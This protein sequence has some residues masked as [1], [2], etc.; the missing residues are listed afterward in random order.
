VTVFTLPCALLAWLLV[1]AA[2]AQ[3]ATYTVGVEAIDHYPLYATRKGEYLGFARDVLDAFARHS[4]HTLVYQPMPIRRLHTAFLLDRK[5]DL[6]FPDNAAWQ[7]ASRRGI[8]VVYSQSVATST[9]G[10]L[11]RPERRGQGLAKT[12]TVGTVLGFTPPALAA[13]PPGT[14][15]VV[16]NSSLDGLLQQVIL[17]RLDAAF[18]SI[19]VTLPLLAAAST[20]PRLVFDPGL[21]HDVTPLYLSSIRHPAVIA[22][23]NAF[24]I[25]EQRLVN[26]LRAR[27]QLTR[28]GS[29]G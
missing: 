5:V 15:K 11:V 10:M 20:P 3:A 22:E 13:L 21:P 28:P 26:A 8:N 24:L 29:S 23:F 7:A 18:V 17:G 27:Y 6:K 2:P 16:E 1:F 19:D 4:G 9:G 25:R 12:R 14:I